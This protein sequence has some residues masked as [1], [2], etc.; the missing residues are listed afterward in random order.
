MKGLFTHKTHFLQGR[1]CYGHITLNSNDK[2]QDLV[3]EVGVMYIHSPFIH[4]LTRQSRY[5]DHVA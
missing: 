5:F 4:D 2:P 3:L 1:S